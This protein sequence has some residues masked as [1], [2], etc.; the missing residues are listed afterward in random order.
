MFMEVEAPGG[1]AREMDEE[2]G[3]WRKRQVSVKRCL[4]KWRQNGGVEAEADWLRSWMKSRC[5]SYT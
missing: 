5:V 4:W 3:W 1:G 2:A